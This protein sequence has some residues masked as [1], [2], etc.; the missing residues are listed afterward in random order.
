MKTQISITWD[1]D[2]ILER[3]YQT[4]QTINRT[5]ACEVLLLM[6]RKHDCNV[7]INW[8]MIDVWIDE[9]QRSNR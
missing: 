5:Q 1:I 3:A 9:I 8:G 4:A 7:G 2:D 6:E